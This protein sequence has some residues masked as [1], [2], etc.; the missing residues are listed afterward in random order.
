[1]R[2]SAAIL[3]ALVAL[4]GC[5]RAAE[6]GPTDPARLINSFAAQLDQA[7]KRTYTAE[8]RVADGGAVSVAQAQKPL[9]TAY[10]HLGGR[11]VIAPEGFTTCEA[12][13]CGKPAPTPAAGVPVAI[14][15]FLTA[16]DALRQISS[17]SLTDRGALTSHD[18][19]IAGQHAL[20]LTIG[21]LDAC[22]TDQGVL[23]SFVGEVNGA[24]IDIILTRYAE[25]V[26]ADAFATS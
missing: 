1:M 13:T 7:T 21:T 17:A 4:A 14:P 5:T 20:C 22:V 19:T 12:T 6:A 11:I 24:K 15:G 8:Y 18:R 3:F 23:G 25:S 16:A 2:R 9:R 10:T 26:T